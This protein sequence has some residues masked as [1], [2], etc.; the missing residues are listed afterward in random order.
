MSQKS[1]MSPRRGFVGLPLLLSLLLSPAVRSAGSPTG[2]GAA[3]QTRQTIQQ[4]TASVAASQVRPVAVL[5]LRGQATAF[6]GPTLTATVPLG[7][8]AY[9]AFGMSRGW[10]AFSS[11]QNGFPDERLRVVDVL[12]REERVL[13]DN[14][15]VAGAA[16]RPGHLQLAAVAYR[17]LQTSLLM[18]NVITGEATAIS[19]RP[20]N[21][22]ALR[23]TDDGTTLFAV[24]EVHPID[25]RSPD[26]TTFL[27]AQYS[28]EGTLL[29]ETAVHPA[30]LPTLA[31]VDDGT[32]SGLLSQPLSLPWDRVPAALNPHGR[33]GGA[34]SRHRFRQPAVLWRSDSVLLVKDIGG[35]DQVDLYS[36][37]VVSGSV[38]A[39]TSGKY[40]SGTIPPFETA[41]ST[42][43]SPSHR[44]IPPEGVERAEQ[45]AI[46]DEIEVD[47]I[48]QVHDLANP[49]ADD[50]ERR[51]DGVGHPGALQLEKREGDRGEHDVMRPA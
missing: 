23:W 33:L 11:L 9:R 31:A 46:V 21:P 22:V 16:W 6:G 17:N 40:P 45:L 25:Q 1:M 42:T 4:I 35:S 32:L 3:C 15:M 18:V 30:L 7:L 47:E 50:Q 12:T 24:H 26:Q 20:T 43:L 29:G 49:A 37:D 44:R 28:A 5:A 38:V 48:E 13:L 51:D 34:S 8:S 36:V 39:I 41:I 14:W 10:L 27:L 19:S 2:I